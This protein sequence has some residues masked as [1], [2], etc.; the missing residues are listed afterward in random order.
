MRGHFRAAYEAR[1]VIVTKRL[2]V[3]KG[4]EHW[5]GLV[6]YMFHALHVALARRGV[7]DVHHDLLGGFSFASARLT[8]FRE[9]AG[10]GS[11]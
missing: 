7:G 11:T 10:S 2:G 9:G 6:D 5:I 4:L 3:T 1:G 8:S